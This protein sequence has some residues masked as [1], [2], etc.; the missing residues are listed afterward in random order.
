[1]P[2][3]LLCSLNQ[4]LF[5]KT[6][7]MGMLANQAEI[8]VWVQAS[9]PLL[10]WYRVSPAEKCKLYMQNPAT[11]YIFGRKIVRNAIHNVLLNTLTTGTWFPHVSAAFQQWEWHSC[12]FPLEMTHRCE[13]P[14][15]GVERSASLTETVYAVVRV[16]FVRCA[17]WLATAPRRCSNTLTPHTAMTLRQVSLQRPTPTLR[18][19]LHRLSLRYYQFTLN[20][21]RETTECSSKPYLW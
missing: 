11:W 10:R 4:W 19:L 18:Y 14:V 1:M 15:C 6:G 9:G 16:S 7:T 8:A 20:W 13:F 21:I 2:S 17:W 3:S 12:M 5:C